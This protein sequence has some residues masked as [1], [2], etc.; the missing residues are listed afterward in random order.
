[1]AVCCREGVQ[2]DGIVGR[3]NRGMG[4]VMAFGVAFMGLAMFVGQW[5]RKERAEG[6]VKADSKAMS[7]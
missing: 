7:P 5:L 6:K 2:L 1:M 3:V 4:F